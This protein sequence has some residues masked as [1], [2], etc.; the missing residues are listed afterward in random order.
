MNNVGSLM[1]LGTCCTEVF[2]LLDRNLPDIHILAGT[3][4]SGFKSSMSSFRGC[5]GSHEL[6]DKLTTAAEIETAT[7]I[8]SG[9]DKPT[10]SMPASHLSRDGGAVGGLGN[11]SGNLVIRKQQV[12][13]DIRPNESVGTVGNV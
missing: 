10:V 6:C 9:K 7:P 1:N 11:K 2:P 12:E 8:F 13:L 4:G 5:D 3:V